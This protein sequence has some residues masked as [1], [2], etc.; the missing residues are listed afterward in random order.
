[1]DK[2]GEKEPHSS[3]SLPPS[4]LMLQGSL[5]FYWDVLCGEGPISH[6]F[7]RHRHKLKI[8]P[9]LSVRAADYPSRGNPTMPML[10]SAKHTSVI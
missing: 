2:A 1:M 9:S 3:S 6:L 8:K 10:C 7:Q 5:P 4:R